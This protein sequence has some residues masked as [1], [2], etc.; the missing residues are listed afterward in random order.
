MYSSES[1]FSRTGQP[2]LPIT[3][4]SHEQQSPNPPTPVS[5]ARREVSQSTS[6]NAGM[7]ITFQVSPLNVAPEQSSILSSEPSDFNFLEYGVAT[8]V[9]LIRSN[10]PFIRGPL[11]MPSPFSSHLLR[12]KERKPAKMELVGRLVSQMICS[13]PE[14]R[15]NEDSCPSFI[16][17]SIFRRLLNTIN[18]EDPIVVC[19]DITR[20]FTARKARSDFSVWDAIVSEQERIYDQRGSFDKWLHLSSAQAMTIYILMLAAEGE[21]VLTHYPNLPITLLFTLGSNFKQLNQI[22]PGFVAAKEHSADRPAWEDWIFA[23]SKLRTA[24]VYF[25]LGLHFDIDFGL[26][27]DR[28]SDYEF[29]DVD[30]PAAKV[31]W[32]AKNE[33]SWREEF[34]LAEQARDNFIPVSTNET[35]LKY[36]DLVRFNKQQRGYEYPDSEKDES[37]LAARIGNWQKGVDEF[38]MLVALCSTMV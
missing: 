16:H 7:F 38:G 29:E 30:L 32:E 25:I 37:K 23:E 28:E 27:C 2:S 17:H 5:G 26:P 8:K 1:L 12:P 33:V 14:R 21:S 9:P 24:T 19:Q 18:S 10:M 11:E 20:K 4:P 34:D 22:L 35:R 36:G 3:P 15:M 13:F 6:L 31:L